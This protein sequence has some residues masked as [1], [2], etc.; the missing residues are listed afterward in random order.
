MS[1]LIDHINTM[2]TK[3]ARHE[4]HKEKDRKQKRLV[5]ADCESCSPAWRWRTDMLCGTCS[6][7]WLPPCSHVPKDDGDREGD[8]HFGQG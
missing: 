4:R 1:H 3:R 6:I 8:V 2:A 5:S 7:V